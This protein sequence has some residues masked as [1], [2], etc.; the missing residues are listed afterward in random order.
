ME[1]E[2][3]KIITPVDKIE[4][5]IY[6]WIT[7]G[8]LEEIQDIYLKDYE[9]SVGGDKPNAT[10]NGSMVKTINHKQIEKL[11]MS[12][13]GI[14]EN[15]LQSILNLKSSDYQFVI[16]EINKVVNAQPE[17]EKKNT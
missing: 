2:T 11:I 4:V 14:K 13:K 12:V 9:V 7:G 8:E 1:R 16:E 10:L 5:E 6:T 3:K 17:L 15:V